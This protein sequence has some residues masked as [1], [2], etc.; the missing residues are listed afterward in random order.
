MHVIIG[1]YLLMYLYIHACTYVCKLHTC[2]YICI[3]IL[4][5]VLFAPFCVWWFSSCQGIWAFLLHI[6]NSQKISHVREKVIFG[7]KSLS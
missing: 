4:H 3:L 2:I 6:P 5:A 1:A 7:V